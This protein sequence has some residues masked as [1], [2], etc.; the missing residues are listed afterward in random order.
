MRRLGDGAGRLS[1]LARRSLPR[2]PLQIVC[3]KV[4]APPLRK[5][6]HDKRVRMRHALT[7]E[8]SQSSTS[9]SRTSKANPCLSQPE[10]PTSAARGALR[11]KA[12]NSPDWNCVSEPSDQAAHDEHNQICADERPEDGVYPLRGHSRLGLCFSTVFFR[13]LPL[14]LFPLSARKLSCAPRRIEVRAR[15]CLSPSTS[16]AFLETCLLQFEIDSL[17]SR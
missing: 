17:L 16:A 1:K 14:L 9:E 11:H 5:H 4:G 6:K 8:A 3:I 12:S 10:W 7:V 13:R 15:L 2:K